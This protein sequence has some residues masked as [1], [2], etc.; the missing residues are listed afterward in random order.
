MVS[1]FTAG[2][3]PLEKRSEAA[4]CWEDLQEVGKLAQSCLDRL[5]LT[6]PNKKLMQ[7]RTELENIRLHIKIEPNWAISKVRS[8]SYVPTATL[9]DLLNHMCQ[10]ECFTCS[11]TAVEARKCP[12]RKTIEDALP[13]EVEHPEYDGCKYSDM[14]LGL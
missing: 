1:A 10:T 9:N 7:I 13:H 14:T 4:G 6:V 5:L 11:K 12:H 8:M 2:I 3:D